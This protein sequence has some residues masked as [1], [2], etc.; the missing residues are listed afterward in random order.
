MHLY[1]TS[2]LDVFWR[3]K[4]LLYFVSQDMEVF[5]LLLVEM[6][7][8]FGMG[9]LNTNSVPVVNAGIRV[10]INDILVLI[11]SIFKTFFT[12]FVSFCS[13]FLR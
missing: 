6:E 7:N 12:Y 5:C 2:A 4:L 1:S 11:K 13:S 9:Q 8:A 10:N 3:A